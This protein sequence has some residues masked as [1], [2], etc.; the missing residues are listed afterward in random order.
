MLPI[1]PARQ[2]IEREILLETAAV[3]PLLHEQT[4]A[5]VLELLLELLDPRKRRLRV[6]LGNQPG[7]TLPARADLHRPIKQ[8]LARLAQL[9]ELVD[10]RIQLAARLLDRVA[11]TR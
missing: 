2:L 1:E 4:D 8:R 6:R 7:A 9:P 10:Q 11:G 3:E 5:D